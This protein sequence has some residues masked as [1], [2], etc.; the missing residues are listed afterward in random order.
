VG[1]SFHDEVDPAKRHEEELELESGGAGVRK[2]LSVFGG[3][4]RNRGNDA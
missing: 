1:Y 3:V 2:N 4:S